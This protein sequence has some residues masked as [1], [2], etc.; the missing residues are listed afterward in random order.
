MC[1]GADAPPVTSLI[2]LYL[3]HSK[4]RVLN[5]DEVKKKKN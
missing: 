1:P 2:L 5:T 3:Q 4:A